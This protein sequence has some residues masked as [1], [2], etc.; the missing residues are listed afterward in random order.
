MIALGRTGNAFSGNF[1]QVGL[2]RSGVIF[3]GSSGLEEGIGSIMILLL[4]DL[5]AIQVMMEQRGLLEGGR[6]ML[7]PVCHFPG[8]LIG[9]DVV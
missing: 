3:L 7:S 1:P 5:V 6:H 4:G 9:I 8:F 2:G